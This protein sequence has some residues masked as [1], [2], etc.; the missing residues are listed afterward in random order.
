MLI[1]MATH[2]STPSSPS[3]WH[4]MTGGH[5]MTVLLLSSWLSD[6]VHSSTKFTD[7]YKVHI[8]TI[9]ENHFWPIRDVIH[10]IPNVCSMMR[11]DEGASKLN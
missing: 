7:K 2:N 8:N 3:G 6:C 10:Y 4:S 11:F 5:R 1:K 9:P